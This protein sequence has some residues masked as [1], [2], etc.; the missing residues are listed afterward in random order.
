MEQEGAF[1]TESRS[2]ADPLVAEPHPPSAR[3]RAG[4][5][6]PECKPWRGCR[7]AGISLVIPQAVARTIL[8]SP[9]DR[10]ANCSP[11]FS[12]RSTRL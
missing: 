7:S 10:T 1:V 4:R 12:S 3:R 2:T 11:S 6:G 5:L 9:C 8:R